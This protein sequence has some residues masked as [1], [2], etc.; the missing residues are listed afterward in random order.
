MK[1]KYLVLIV[2][3]L[4]S[5]LT[6]AKK[7]C[8]SVENVTI[9]RIGCLDFLLNESGKETAIISLF[10]GA[11]GIGNYGNEELL[12]LGIKPEEKLKC[13]DSYP[14]IKIKDDKFR[15][16]SKKVCNEPPQN[17]FHLNG[18]LVNISIVRPFLFPKDEG[19]F[20]VNIDGVDFEQIDFNKLLVS[21]AG[22]SL[23]IVHVALDT[24]GSKSPDIVANLKGPEK[25]R[26]FNK[27][28]CAHRDTGNNFFQIDGQTYRVKEL[29][30]YSD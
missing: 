11:D 20:C 13:I 5:G 8:T 29:E 15:F 16:F 26:F 22:E 17:R 14:S 19:E 4:F 9:E 3:I 7:I 25:Y 21:K 24:S 28:L 30:K 6:F 18:S 23:A 2:C 12:I 1:G 10:S 27:Y